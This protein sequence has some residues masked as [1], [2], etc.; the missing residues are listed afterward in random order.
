MLVVGH[1]G[2]RHEAPENTI[3][4]FRHAIDLGLQVVE[5]DIRMSRDGELAIVHDATVD[6]TTNGSGNVADLTLAE[7][8]AL[9]ARSIHADWPEPARIPNFSEVLDAVGSLPVILVEIKAD[10]NERL[11]LIVPKAIAEIR[12]RGLERQAAI[13]SFNIHA[14][15]IA[16]RLAPEI[17]RGYIGNWDTPE[18][19]DVA[20]RL[21]CRH[22]HPYHPTADRALVAQAKASGFEVSGWQTNSAGDLESVLTLNPDY[23]SSDVPTLITGL[24]AERTAAAS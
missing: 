16:H 22:V 6:R 8:Q 2:A 20:T 19:L 5:F 24:L 12:A 3:T 15:E 18:F 4:G 9:D 11:D 1:R 7:L 14:L 23:I 10:T 21:E 13:I 17:D